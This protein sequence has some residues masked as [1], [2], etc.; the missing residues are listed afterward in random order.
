MNSRGQI[1]NSNLFMLKIRSYVECFDIIIVKNLRLKLIHKNRISSI[2]KSCS[3]PLS[4]HRCSITDPWKHEF[5]NWRKP[6]WFWNGFLQLRFFQTLF[7]EIAWIQR[8]LHRQTLTALFNFLRKTGA[9]LKSINI[10]ARYGNTTSSLRI[11]SLVA[12][13]SIAARRR[14]R[15]AGR[16]EWVW[17]P[18]A[19]ADYRGNHPPSA[20]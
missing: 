20:N 16:L 18:L 17:K 14:I 6:I 11:T 1:L 4:S 2:G 9:V 13:Y 19:R 8:C 10:F 5:H 3:F 15:S 7:F 12:T